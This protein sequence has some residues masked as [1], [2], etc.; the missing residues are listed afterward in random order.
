MDEV[1]PQHVSELSKIVLSESGGFAGDE[2]VQQLFAEAVRKRVLE[3]LT[4]ANEAKRNASPVAK[5][6]E[7]A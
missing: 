6:K 2:M 4:Q 1:V 7:K 5:K 3:E